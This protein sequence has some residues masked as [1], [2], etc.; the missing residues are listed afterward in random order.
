MAGPETSL[1]DHP[2]TLARWLVATQRAGQQPARGRCMD[3]LTMHFHRDVRVPELDRQP[4]HTPLTHG[5]LL[6]IFFSLGTG[7]FDTP[8]GHHTGLLL[9]GASIDNNLRR[10]VPIP[11]LPMPFGELVGLVAFRLPSPPPS[12][13]S[14]AGKL[15]F[16]RELVTRV[17]VLKARGRVFDI[18]DGLGAAW[19]LKLHRGV[20]ESGE[21]RHAPGDCAFP[22]FLC[23]LPSIMG[24][25]GPHVVSKRDSLTKVCP[26]LP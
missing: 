2:G 21:S 16:A 18:Q 9:R 1:G 11:A 14:T 17:V 26:Q 4:L 5:R 6:F 20:R 19:L 8:Q 10:T 22:F 23:S 7:P 24:I 15:G 25:P 3:S 12:L 13:I